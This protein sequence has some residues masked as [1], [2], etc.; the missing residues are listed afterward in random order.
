MRSNSRSSFKFLGITTKEAANF[1]VSVDKHT[2]L[3]AWQIYHESGLSVPAI[4]ALTRNSIV[5]ED[6]F[7]SDDPKV[8]LD[9]L[10]YPKGLG[11]TWASEIIAKRRPL[12][13][14]PD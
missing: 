10:D 11:M 13:E 6:L 14:S 3:S 7:Q 9:K 8:L 1:D 4:N 2:G 12:P 5:P